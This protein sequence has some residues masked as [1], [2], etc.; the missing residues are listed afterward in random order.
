MK[1]IWGRKFPLEVLAVLLGMTA[2]TV[3]GTAVGQPQPRTAGASSVE[4]IGSTLVCPDL[5][6]AAGTL[7]SRVSIGVGPLPAGRS[8]T[9]GSVEQDLVSAP[10]KASPIGLTAPGQV[11]VNLGTTVTGD[12]IQ[13]SATGPLAASLEA[14]QLTEG[15]AGR[16]RGLAGLRCGAPSTDTWFEGGGTGTGDSMM[17]ILVNV[18]DTPATVD[19]SAYGAKGLPLQPN[20]GQ[21][22]TV[23]PHSRTIQ[24][25]DTIFPDM[26]LTALHVVGRRG[27]VVAAVR[28]SNVTRNQSVGVDWVPEAA[29]PATKVVVSGFPV[30]AGGQRDLLITNPSSDSTTVS[31]QVTT[32]TAQFVPTGLDQ[33]VVPAAST[34]AILLNDLT[35]A[36]ALSARITST[37]APVLAGG[38]V[39]DTQPG[40]EESD[41]GFT[42]GSGP[43]SGP[44]L[45]TDLVIDRPT[46]SS[47]IL[48]APDAGATVVITPIRVNG[49]PGALPAPK[50]LTI[51]AGR[52]LVLKLSTFYPPATNAKLA[53]E[54]RPAAGSGPVYA[55]RYLREHGAHGP[56]TTLLD[57][58]GPAREVSRP[59]A[60]SDPRLGD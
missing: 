39:L 35:N 1:A 36:T 45:L 57:L 3:V 31:I 13:F 16:E 9:G 26:S 52:T 44:T 46:E 49:T 43:L 42:A 41:F 34:V 20:A 2:L 53:V 50:T 28:Y 12:A 47:L 25:V 51:P 4:V 15:T 55:A 59:A 32:Q 5:R 23:P 33:V 7:A 58:Q 24:A 21:G 18:D 19:V 11:V 6:Q 8:E 17:M 29:P 37:G 60:S 30:N 22:I 48:S 14:E 27:R 56:L 54:V 10:A 38:F 40:S